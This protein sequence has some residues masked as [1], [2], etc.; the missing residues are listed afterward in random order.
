MDKSGISFLMAERLT[1]R[2]VQIN[3]TL[4]TVVVRRES[5]YR[6]IKLKFEPARNTKVE[7]ASIT[8]NVEGYQFKISSRRYS[9]L[10]LI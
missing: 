9:G 8:G 10:L 6:I 1:K 5:S 4:L 7:N 2:G 3:L